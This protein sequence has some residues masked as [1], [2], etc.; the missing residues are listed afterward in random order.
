MPPF[1]S[2]LVLCENPQGY[3]I[4]A[5]ALLVGLEVDVCGCLFVVLCFVK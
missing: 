1:P 4:G 2:L 3:D 5:V